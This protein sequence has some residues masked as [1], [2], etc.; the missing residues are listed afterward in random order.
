MFRLCDAPYQPAPECAVIEKL[1]AGPFNRV[2]TLFFAALVR[3]SSP[4]IQEEVCEIQIDIPLVD[5]LATRANP[6]H[7][8]PAGFRRAFIAALPDD[9]FPP[10]AP[11]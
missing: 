8:Y 11:I 4:Y 6:E 10:W 9:F 2:N 1:A 3:S 5:V 7:P